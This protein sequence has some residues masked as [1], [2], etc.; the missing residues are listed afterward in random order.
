MS[1]HQKV[2]INLD[3]LYEEDVINF[4]G[5]LY[6]GVGLFLLIVITFGLMWILQF[7]VL[8]PRTD[9]IN[10]TRA[11]PLAMTDE[12]NLPPD[13]R[14]QSAP[15]FGVET[16]D[17]F[18]NLELR[19]PQAEWNE[20]QKQYKGIWEHGEKSSDGKTIIAMPI[21]EAKEKLLKDG[22]LKA[23]TGED[24]KNAL[25][26]ATKYISGSS[27]GRVASETRR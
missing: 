9:E 22:G 11:N 2:E 6:F 21:E 26:A 24:G 5:I 19:E 14:L 20:L 10:K 15:G 1:K 16:K 25:E 17:G 13:H 7:Y 18:V 8:Q 12:E 23:A 4:T 3:K 27:A